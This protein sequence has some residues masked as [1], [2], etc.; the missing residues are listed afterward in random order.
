MKFYYLT[1]AEINN[2]RSGLMSKKNR[3]NRKNKSYPSSETKSHKSKSFSSF[4]K[5]AKKTKKGHHFE[6]NIKNILKIEY[7][8]TDVIK[9]THFFYRTIQ[10]ASKKIL[11]KLGYSKTLIINGRRYKFLL[12]PNQCFRI[13]AGYISRRFITNIT[14]KNKETKINLINVNIIVS[15]I[16]ENRNRCFYEI[17]F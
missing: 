17:D 14:E 3:K 8:W 13:I 2:L 1:D 6:E 4:Y 9:D 12:Y 15:K 16:N 10:I 7:G 11:L 5:Q